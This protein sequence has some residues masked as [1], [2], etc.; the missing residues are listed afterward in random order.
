MMPQCLDVGGQRPR[1][2]VLGAAGGL[3]WGISGCALGPYA[4]QSQDLAIIPGSLPRKTQTTPV[5]RVNVYSGSLYCTD[6]W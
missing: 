5:Y 6:H 4:L 1:R 2:P 3:N